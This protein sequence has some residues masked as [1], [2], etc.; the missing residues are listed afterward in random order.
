M[1]KT[2]ENGVIV[3]IDLDNLLISSA[4]EGREFKGYSTRAGFHNMFEWIKGF[5][6]IICAHIYLSSRTYQSLNDQ[7]W[8]GLW[9]EYKEEFLFG[10]VYCPKVSIGSKLTD[11]V[12]NHLTYHTEKLAKIFADQTRYFCLAAG[13]LDYSPLLWRLKRN[14][15][16]EIAFAPGSQESFSNVYQQIKI[17]ARHPKTGE[18]LIHYFSPNKSK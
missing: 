7:L 9:G 12:D 17:A 4:Q 14:M 18:E 15:G 16:I 11:N 6:E 5:S 10:Y 1:E 3:A 8:D 2:T 13:D